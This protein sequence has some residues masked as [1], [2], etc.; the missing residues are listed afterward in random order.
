MER[1]I[2]RTVEFEGSLL[3]LEVHQVEL[4]DGS[5]A[6]R[7]LVFHADA[8]CC[9]VVT[10]SLQ[11]VL[12]KQY[13]KPVEKPILEI[14]AGKI[15]PG[16]DPATAVTRELREEVGFQ[17]GQVEFL[18]DFYAS[19]GF[20]NEKLGLYLATNAVLGEQM[21]DEGE[22]L[23]LVTVP[24]AEAKRMALAGELGDA[25]SVAG[26]LAAAARLGI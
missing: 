9:V 24:F 15:D 7:E 11:T 13:R 25:K 12:V 26:V 2:S 20:C 16:E 6:R 17:S 21:L 3:T 5:L 10:E 22:F 23:E 4:R 1:T 8:V 18:M 19:P 14:P